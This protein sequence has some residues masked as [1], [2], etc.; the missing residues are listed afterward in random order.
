MRLEVIP[1][2]AYENKELTPR[3]FIQNQS[4]GLGQPLALESALNHGDRIYT[5]LNTVTQLRLEYELYA[6]IGRG[7]SVRMLKEQQLYFEH[8]Q[9]RCARV[10]QD[11]GDTFTI[12]A[13][14]LTITV[15]VPGDVFV[16]SLFGEDGLPYATVVIALMGKVE[17]KHNNG[18]TYL[19]D[20]PLKAYAF[21]K[22]GWNIHIN[23]ISLDSARLLEVAATDGPPDAYIL[24]PGLEEQIPV[25]AGM[26]L[27]SG[28]TLV[29]G[30][31][32]LVRFQLFDGSHLVLGP[33]ARL[34]MFRRRVG[35]SDMQTVFA[36]YQG[37]LRGKLSY[38]ST[39]GVSIVKP[40]SQVGAFSVWSPQTTMTYKAP[41]EFLFLHEDKIGGRWSSQS[42]LLNLDGTMILTDR[43]G[44]PVKEMPE[45][46]QGV[47][48]PLNRSMTLT[49]QEIQSRLEAHPFFMDGEW[50]ADLQDLAYER[51]MGELQA[52]SKD[53]LIFKGISQPPPPFVQQD[54]VALPAQATPDS[55]LAT[56]PTQTGTPLPLLTELAETLPVSR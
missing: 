14:D 4:N 29:T 35:A 48:W 18:L 36:L 5:N 8:G 17:V 6:V 16:L 44:V 31:G 41:G 25:K 46:G 45:R 40:D 49:E 53:F 52:Q 28:D 42:E 43:V 33:D 21:D 24:R 54:S 12:F 9:L 1:S 22:D 32:T 10:G 3:A 23:A 19:L 47:V 13:K 27:E 15:T 50:Y 38:D 51:G 11:E 7:S 2:L 56:V 30:K 39:T 55:P 26:D 34:N 37:Q 20:K